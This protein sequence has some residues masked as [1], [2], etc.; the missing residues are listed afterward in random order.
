MSGTDAR[1]STSWRAGDA[2]NDPERWIQDHG[3]ALYRVARSRVRSRDAAEDLVQETFLA[4]LKTRREFEGRSSVRTW[5]ISILR[6]QVVNYIRSTARSRTSAKNDDIDPSGRIHAAFFH[7]NGK[8][9]RPPAA[10]KGSFDTLEARELWSVFNSCL[11]KLP[12]PFAEAFI[13]REFEEI[14]SRHT[15]EIL[16][17]TEENLR[18][19][20][21]RARLLLRACLEHFGI[22]SPRVRARVE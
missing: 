12:R 5:L 11:D 3:D 22:R 15:C 7:R 10:S 13:L 4:A 6:R 21:H 18:V 20:L 16:D 9:R 14:E 8:W 1:H 2:E 19:R 17:I